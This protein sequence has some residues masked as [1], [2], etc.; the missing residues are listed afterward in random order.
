[1]A[2][3][4]L[5]ARVALQG[6]T[7]AWHPIAASPESMAMLIEKTSDKKRYAKGQTSISRTDVKTIYAVRTRIR[8]RAIG[9]LLG[10]W[11]GAYATAAVQDDALQDLIPVG[12]VIRYYVL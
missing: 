2:W 1:M 3:S 10:L 9:T 5:T 6:V 12:A 8:G 4:G 7:V 11:G